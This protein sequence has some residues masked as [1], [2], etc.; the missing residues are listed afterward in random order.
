MGRHQKKLKQKKEVDELQA[1]WRNDLVKLKDY[2]DAS[3]D[4]D[5]RMALQIIIDLINEWRKAK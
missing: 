4:Q 2:Q 5:A 1:D 3:N